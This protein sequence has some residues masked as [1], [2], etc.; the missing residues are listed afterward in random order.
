MKT[1]T[2]HIIT[3][4]GRYCFL[5]LPLGIDS[6]FPAQE[7][8]LPGWSRGSHSLHGWRPVER[9]DKGRTCTKSLQL[10][11]NHHLDIVKCNSSY[12]EFK[13]AVANRL[14]EIMPTLTCLMGVFS[15]PNPWKLLLSDGSY[16]IKT[17]TPRLEPRYLRC[18]VAT[19]QK[20]GWQIFIFSGRVALAKLFH[21]PRTRRGWSLHSQDA[22]CWMLQQGFNVS[23]IEVMLSLIYIGYLSDC[24]LY[25]SNI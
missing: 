18:L 24:I 19:V 10:F 17:V 9:E 22:I 3:P 4:Y 20:T 11:N 14:G 1:V 12:R 5:R 7:A 6:T 8:G 13:M 25:I 15:K 2:C 16:S 23:V 21:V